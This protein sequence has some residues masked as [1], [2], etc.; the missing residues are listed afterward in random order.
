MVARVNRE[1]LSPLIHAQLSYDELRFWRVFGSSSFLIPAELRYCLAG[2]YVLRYC[3]L[4][5]LHKGPCTKKR[6]SNQVPA[7]I[8]ARVPSDRGTQ[9]PCRR[10]A[11]WLEVAGGH[12]AV[13]GGSPWLEVAGGRGWRRLAAVAGGGGPQRTTGAWAALF[14]G[15]GMLQRT[16]ASG[17]AGGSEEGRH[18]RRGDLGAS[19]GRRRRVGGGPGEETREKMT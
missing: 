4:Q 13:A 6:K 5:I 17:R 8:L 3:L 11:P 19:R 7:S 9:R 16:T 1:S 14:G 15:G 18:G 10:E 12:G 2:L